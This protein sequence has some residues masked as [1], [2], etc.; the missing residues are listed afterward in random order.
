MTGSLKGGGRMSLLGEGPAAMQ[1]L[2]ETAEERIDVEKIL[3]HRGDWLLI[4]EVLAHDPDHL[5]ADYQVPLDPSWASDHFP[6]TP[7]MPGV[8]L[9][10]MGNQALALHALL[11][12]SPER[13]ERYLPILT[14]LNW[15]FTGVVKPGD[16]LTIQ[17]ELDPSSTRAEKSAQVQIVKDLT[18]VARGQSTGMVCPRNRV[19]NGQ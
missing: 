6:G 14:K 5:V 9:V 10:E 18:T 1:A 15:V 8:L 3:P 2:L 17:I 4:S 13:R 19:L 11:H 7:L 16:L 12:I